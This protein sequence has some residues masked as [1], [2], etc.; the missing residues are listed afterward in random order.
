M[1]FR[2]NRA[3]KGFFEDY[4]GEMVLSDIR[5]FKDDKDF[6]EQAQKYVDETRGQHMPLSEPV[7]LSIIYNNE[8]AEDCW[9]TKSDAEKINFHGEEITVYQSA[10]NNEPIKR[11]RRGEFTL[12]TKLKLHKFL[13]SIRLERGEILR[14]M[15][16]RLGMS[17]SELSSIELGKK[18][19]P[20][21]F[22]DKI[23]S[24]YL[25]GE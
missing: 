3:I 6:M 8:G 13:R 9:K 24:H 19:L 5:N 25:N 2:K 14:D 1:L 18:P 20:K 11:F 16:K 22:L 7:V 12:D 10:I 21:G 15:A 17:P 23:Q 4:D